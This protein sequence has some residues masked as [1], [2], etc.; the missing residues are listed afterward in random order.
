MPIPARK[1]CWGCK[2][3]DSLRS[4][5]DK[6]LVRLKSERDSNCLPEWRE[7]SD[8]IMP[9]AGRFNTS[10]VNQGKRR[11][12]KIINP[13]A[14]FAARTLAA[15]MHSGMTSPGVTVVQAWHP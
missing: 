3:A 4:Q 9:R 10:D 6:R 12:K 1:R 5:L 13:R 7:L 8:F 15:G 2:L 11:D 14:S